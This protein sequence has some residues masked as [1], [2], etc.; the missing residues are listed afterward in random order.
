MP[1]A[2]ID[3]GVQLINMS[4]SQDDAL[5]KDIPYAH[6]IIALPGYF[7]VEWPEAQHGQHVQIDPAEILAPFQTCTQP[8]AYTLPSSIV[9]SRDYFSGPRPLDHADALRPSVAAPT[10]GS[11]SFEDPFHFDWPHW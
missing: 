6:R 7:S 10:E 3:N 4:V 8:T 2:K 5:N 1:K 9:P 11:P